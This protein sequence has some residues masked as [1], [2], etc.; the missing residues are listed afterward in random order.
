M[1]IFHVIAYSQ[2][3]DKLWFQDSF[4]CMFRMK[5]LFMQQFMH[6]RLL[7][8]HFCVQPIVVRK[9]TTIEDCN[10]QKNLLMFH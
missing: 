5:R 10:V 2:K 6:V 3:S 4:K 9:S 8:I 1:K 7:E